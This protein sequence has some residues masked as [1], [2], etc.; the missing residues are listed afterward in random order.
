MVTSQGCK[1]LSQASWARLE[2]IN[3]GSV[4]PTL[5]RNNVD[6]KGCAYLVKA[7]W[8]HLSKVVLG[9]YAMIEPIT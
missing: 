2:V 4:L 3:I 7:R 9:T 1:Y 8:P 6:R 5:A